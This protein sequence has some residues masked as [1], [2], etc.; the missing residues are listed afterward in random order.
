MS[1]MENGRGRLFIV[2][3]GVCGDG[4]WRL[5]R[6]EGIG[7]CVAGEWRMVFLLEQ[8]CNHS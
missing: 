1:K 8:K 3:M 5:G 4:G 2:G 7:G 6:M